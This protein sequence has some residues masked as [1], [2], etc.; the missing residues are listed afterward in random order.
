MNGNQCLLIFCL[1]LPRLFI[2]LFIFCFAKSNLHFYQRIFL[3][4]NVQANGGLNTV[5]LICKDDI[6]Q[7]CATGPVCPRTINDF[8]ACKWRMRARAAPSLNAP[9]LWLLW[10][11]NLFG[12]YKCR[13]NLSDAKQRLQISLWWCTVIVCPVIMPRYI[14]HYLFYLWCVFACVKKTTKK[15]PQLCQSHT[16][17]LKFN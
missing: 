8:F 3:C 7:G 12:H 1:P 17:H 5:N 16:L 13:A 9:P 4:K 10:Q 11:W 6:C 15:P 14:G 2:Y